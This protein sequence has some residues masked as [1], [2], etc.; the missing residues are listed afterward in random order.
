[1][2]NI[3]VIFSLLL[4]AGTL[5]KAIDNTDDQQNFVFE[6]T[7]EVFFSIPES[8]KHTAPIKCTAIRTR[9]SEDFDFTGFDRDEI[10]AENLYSR[11]EYSS[12]HTIQNRFC[13]V[14]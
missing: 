8:P 4:F 1:M 10:L 2:K 5:V 11:N 3:I 12:Q 6:I 13:I 7:P 9:T 14:C